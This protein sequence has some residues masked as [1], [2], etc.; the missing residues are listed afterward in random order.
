M[1]AW[2]LWLGALFSAFAGG[3]FIYVSFLRD[4]VG[5]TDDNGAALLGLLIMFTVGGV[6]LIGRVWSVLGAQYRPRPRSGDGRYETQI[7]NQERRRLLQE[8]H[9]GSLQTATALSLYSQVAGTEALRIQLA[10]KLVGEMRVLL[11]TSPSDRLSQRLDEA[12]R[13]LS[14]Q[15]EKYVNLPVTITV[16]GEK[17]LEKLSTERAAVLFHVVQEGL[18]NV[19]KHA[20]ATESRIHVISSNGLTQVVVQ[21][22]GKGFDTSNLSSRWDVP[23]GLA[24]LKHRIED[25]GGSFVLTSAAGKGT[26]LEAR[27]PHS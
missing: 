1:V 21:D 4:L 2:A 16:M 25:L 11:S 8:M 5:T 20:A 22:N 27:M 10:R 26:K 23:H 18:S 19:S 14:Q 24:L 12:V 6:V 17:D 3:V 9:D 7:R 13:E 15:M